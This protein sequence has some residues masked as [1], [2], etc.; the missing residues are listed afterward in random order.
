MLQTYFLSPDGILIT[1]SGNVRLPESV[2]NSA[3]SF[4]IP[5]KRKLGKAG[6]SKN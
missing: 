6:S 5:A 4:D 1:G 3:L 2:V